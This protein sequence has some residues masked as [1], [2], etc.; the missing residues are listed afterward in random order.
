MNN[1]KVTKYIRFECALFCVFLALFPIDSAFHSL[2]GTISP[3]NY[4]AALLFGCTFFFK[5][6]KFYGSDTIIIIYFYYQLILSVTGPCGLDDRNTVFLFY[7]IFAFMLGR[8][9]WSKKECKFYSYSLLLG[10]IPVIAIVL[11]NVGPYSYFRSTVS[12]SNE[13]DQN[14]L[15]ANMLFAESIILYYLKTAK[16]VWLKMIYIILLLASVTTILFLGSRGGMLG[17]ITV[18]LVFTIL[19]YKKKSWYIIPLIIIAS[20]LILS[21]ITSYMPSWM[22]RRFSFQSM[23]SPDSSLRTQIWKIY[24][25]KYTGFNI[26]NQIFGAGRGASRTLYQYATHNMYLKNLVDGGIIGLTLM[27]TVYTVILKRLIKNHNYIILAAA[28][29][30]LICALFL[31]LDDYRIFG[32]LLALT[33]MPHLESPEVVYSDFIRIKMRSRYSERKLSY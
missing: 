6:Y 23:F 31:D 9:S 11:S 3:N 5:K 30:Y 29:G 26:F 22:Y 18:F 14:Y 1:H 12:L 25:N 20:I 2:W 7:Y 28:F 16:R 19:S 32:V 8:M 13:I 10:L 27:F 4:I 24:Y 33:Y 17:F 15:T 21:I